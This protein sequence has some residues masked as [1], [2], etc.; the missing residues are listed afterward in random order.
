MCTF[1]KREPETIDHIFWSCSIIKSLLM[2]LLSF[3]NSPFCPINIKT[4]I[5]G[6]T[7]KSITNKAKNCILLFIKMFIFQCKTKKCKPTKQCLKRYII[8]KYN[9]EKELAMKVDKAEE[10]ERE[11]GSLIKHIL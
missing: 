5:F 9:I 4:V 6:Y 10:F 2:E 11:W 7:S 3:P 1:C 8:F